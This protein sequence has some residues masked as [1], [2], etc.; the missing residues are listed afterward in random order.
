[1]RK[2]YNNKNSESTSTAYYSSPI[3]VLKITA[4]SSAVCGLI[5][6][7]ERIQ[8]PACDLNHPILKE[9][10]NEL[11]EYF[12]KKRRS[13]DIPSEPRGT[14][15][16]MKVWNELKSIPYGSV[17]TYGEIA[18]KIGS[19]KAYR[20]VGMANHYNPIL[21]MI[22]CHRVIGRNGSLTGFAAGTD[23]KKYLLDLEQGRLF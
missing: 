4:S 2:P 22:P 3:G 8:I 16:Q 1:M 18:A 20:A 7:K 9:C 23:A 14:E 17:C 15:F 11:D 6:M 10:I 21:I 12:F 19:P 13:F 5:C